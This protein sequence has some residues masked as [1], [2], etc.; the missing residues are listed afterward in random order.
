MADIEEGQTA[1]KRTRRATAERQERRRRT[2]EQAD[3]SALSVPIEV[4]RK[5]ADEGLEGRWIN[6]LGNR[7]HNKTKLDDW[8]KV[9]E[10]EPVPVG[11]DSRTG[12]PIMAHYCAKPT[13]YLEADR[14]EH[15]DRLKAREQ[16]VFTGKDHGDMD[17][18]AYNPGSNYIGRRS[19]G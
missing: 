4:Q 19:P 9:P 10:V 8:N 5:L 11:T 3:T 12:K 18:A 15:T 16:A 6:D 13:E 14:R 7:M 1:T 17:E 2:G